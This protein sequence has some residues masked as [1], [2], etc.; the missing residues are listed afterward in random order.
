MAELD[1]VH[2]AILSAM[3]TMSEPAGCRVIA[4]RASLPTPKVVNKMRGL[5]KSDPVA[6]PVEGK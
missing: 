6:S 3:A 1:E 2:R 5:L 4:E